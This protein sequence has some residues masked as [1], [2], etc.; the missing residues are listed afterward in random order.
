MSILF[1][2]IAVFINAIL[3]F[4]TFKK[5]KYNLRIAYIALLIFQAVFVFPIVLE[6]FFGIQDYSYK[7][8]GFHMALNDSK[9]NVI[10]SLFVIITPIIFYISGK[11]NRSKGIIIE[12]IRSTILNLR[13]KRELYVIGVILMFLP[14][15]L[16]LIAPSPEKYLFEYAYFQKFRDLATNP[17][18]WYHRNIMRI[19]EIVSL[20]SI[21]MTKLFSKNTKFNNFLIYFAAII[22]GILNGKRTLLAFIIFEI[23]AVDI[24]KSPKGRFPLKRI[25]FSG[26]FII[27]FFLGYAFLIDKHTANVTTI[28]N[29]RLYFFRDVDVKF[30][31]YALLNPEQ[32]KVLDYWG[33][34]Y[35]F[36]IIFYIPRSLWQNKPYPYDTYVTAAALGY[37]P[38]TL[39]SW[40]F[41]TSIFGEALSNLG[42]FGIPFSLALINKFIKISERSKNP[43]I[44]VLCL[45]I[46]MFSFMNHF[47]SWRNYFIIWLI[48]VFFNKV[49]LKKNKKSFLQSNNK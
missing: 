13:V 8:P 19:G 2:I 26:L 27:I 15:M 6:W 10:Y 4:R 25:V 28:D 38:G 23:L 9:T 30:S 24:L 45:F 33:Q 17:E 49:N 21:L 20:L 7:S 37:Q 42:W 36:N 3:F 29:L 31:I 16:A 11:K 41:Q 48:L 32:Y 46:L 1:Q 22:T 12:D 35:L 14:F 44:N 18:L 47:G 39:I 43:I 5:I 34:S 40:N